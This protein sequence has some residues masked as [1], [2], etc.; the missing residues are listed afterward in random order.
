MDNRY[1]GTGTYLPT[2]R[3]KIQILKGPKQFN[4]YKAEQWHIAGMIL[5]GGYIRGHV[6]KVPVP[7]I[8]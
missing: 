5:N 4:I 3:H 6:M 2:V 7:T 8:K 1:V